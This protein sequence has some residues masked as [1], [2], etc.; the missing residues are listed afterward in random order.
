MTTEVHYKNG[1]LTLSEYCD[2]IG[3]DYTHIVNHSIKNNI[4]LAEATIYYF[5]KM[6]IN[7]LGDLVSPD[8][9]TY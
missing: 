6:Y 8:N 4:S 2:S 1:T 5:P 3:F 7:I 9:N